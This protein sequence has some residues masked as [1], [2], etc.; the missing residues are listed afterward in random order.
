MLL[1]PQKSPKKK[2]DLISNNHISLISGFC[3]LGHD[4][5]LHGFVQLLTWTGLGKSIDPASLNIR[6]IAKFELIC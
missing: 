2:K 6:K 5:P 4:K 1:F 3:P